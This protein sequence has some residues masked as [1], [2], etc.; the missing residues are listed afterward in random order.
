[1]S[2]RDRE[3]SVRLQLPLRTTIILLLALMVGV[4]TGVLLW[5]AAA[6]MA[7]AILGGAGTSA[8]AVLFFDKI[9]ERD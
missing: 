3:S 6:P 4:F 9:I 7:Q 8:A 1:M 5:V 2:K